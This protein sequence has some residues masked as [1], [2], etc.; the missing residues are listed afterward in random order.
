[1]D[2][3]PIAALTPT[4]NELKAR[5]PEVH[6][7]K[8][9]KERWFG[10]RAHIGVDANSGPAHSARGGSSNVNVAIQ[11]NSLQHVKD[12]EAIVDAG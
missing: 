11:A 6:Q 4:K 8:N 12:T 9:G 2:A 7:S 1:M 3:T 10:M 5:D